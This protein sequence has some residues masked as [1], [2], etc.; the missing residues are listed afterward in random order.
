[1]THTAQSMFRARMSPSA[2]YGGQ[3]SSQ[4]EPPASVQTFISFPLKKADSSERVAGGAGAV[5]MIA[6]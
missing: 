6:G 4:T 1:M 3:P 2:G 5:A